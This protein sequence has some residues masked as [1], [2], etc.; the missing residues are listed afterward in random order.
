M[1]ASE[2]ELETLYRRR[3]QTF[4]AG[5]AA[6]TGSRESAGDVVQEAFAQALLRR[7]EFRG[8]GSLE[9][10]VWRIALRHAIDTRRRRRWPLLHGE[11]QAI[12]VAAPAPARES[13]PVLAHAIAALAPRRRLFVFLHYF[14][15]L[16]YAQI[17]EA[18]DVKEGTV[19]AA[20]AQARAELQHALETEVIRGV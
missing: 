14:A 13:D 8:E 17:A 12:E 5:I 3:A 11:E 2:L 15:D 20:L 16:S 1:T 6:I 7:R 18:C 10:W 19:A 9:G 4:R